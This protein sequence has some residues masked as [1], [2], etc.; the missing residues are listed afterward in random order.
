MWHLGKPDELIDRHRGADKREGQLFPNFPLPC[1]PTCCGDKSYVV[2]Q[3]CHWCQPTAP[4]PS[5]QARLSEH[6]VHGEQ[7]GSCVE[8]VAV[9]VDART[10]LS[11]PA[12][13]LSEVE[14]QA[15]R[16]RRNEGRRGMGYE[17]GYTF[18]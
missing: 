9:V 13:R 10:Q 16:Q 1:C 4:G 18:L 3:Q 8:A 7:V 14:G 17:A 5:S 15:D 6:D 11:R 2:E 12:A